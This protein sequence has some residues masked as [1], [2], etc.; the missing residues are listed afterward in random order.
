MIERERTRQPNTGPWSGFLPDA[1]ILGRV[2]SLV[3]RPSPTRSH[4][5]IEIAEDWRGDCRRIS[6][7][8]KV[9]LGAVGTFKAFRRHNVAVLHQPGPA[10]RDTIE[11]TQKAPTGRPQFTSGDEA[12][13]RA[14][15]PDGT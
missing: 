8:A 4:C 10:A 11:K 2:F 14:D 13:Y 7:I 12:S 1:G 15:R 6:D 3:N 5:T 9:T